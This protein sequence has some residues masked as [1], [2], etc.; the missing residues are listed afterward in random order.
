MLTI[1]L[2]SHIVCLRMINT[3]CSYAQ[4]AIMVRHLEIIR[5]VASSFASCRKQREL[6]LKDKIIPLSLM[7]G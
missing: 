1:S 6:A 4:R 2:I 3:R 7:F 5:M